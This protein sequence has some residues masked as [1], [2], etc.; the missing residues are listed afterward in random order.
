[1]GG[2]QRRDDLT[3]NVEGVDAA[4]GALAGFVAA[5]PL[6]DEGARV[7]DVGQAGVHGEG[8]RV[9]DEVVDGRGVG[10]LR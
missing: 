7:R 2:R 3:M 6:R 4:P 8:A 1:M 10:A 5:Q 9:P